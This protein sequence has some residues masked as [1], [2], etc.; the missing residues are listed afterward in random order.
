MTS[1]FAWES[2]EGGRM[3]FLFSS[4][5]LAQGEMVTLKFISFFLQKTG[6]YAQKR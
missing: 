4:S 2:T 1:G 6:S 3:D 5:F